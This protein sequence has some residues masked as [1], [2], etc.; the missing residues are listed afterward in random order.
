MIK[1]VKRAKDPVY[2]LSL[3]IYLVSECGRDL[4]SGEPYH[5]YSEGTD[6]YELK[7]GMNDLILSTLSLY[8]K[9]G[10]CFIEELIECNGKYHDRDEYFGFIDLKN[11]TV[12]IF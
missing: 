5:T 11:K 10:E 4:Q 6:V 2:R 7:K 1:R 8:G 12:E 9:D 3:T